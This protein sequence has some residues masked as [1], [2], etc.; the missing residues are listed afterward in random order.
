VRLDSN[1]RIRFN[2]SEHR[3]FDHGYESR[4]TAPRD[5]RRSV[6]WSMRTPG[7]TRIY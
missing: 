1:R 2:A 6:S 5:S 3:H 4:A 7:Y